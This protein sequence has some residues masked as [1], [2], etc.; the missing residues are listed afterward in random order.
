MMRMSVND[1][2]LVIDILGG[3]NKN[4]RRDISMELKRSKTEVNLFHC[5]SQKRNT[6]NICCITHQQKLAQHL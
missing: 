4:I 1:E 3:T 5:V 6:S 2:I